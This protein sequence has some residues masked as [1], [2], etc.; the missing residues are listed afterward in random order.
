MISLILAALLLIPIGGAQAYTLPAESVTIA[1]R[2]VDDG[3]RG[4]SGVLVELTPAPESGGRQTAVT[5]TDGAYTVKVPKGWTG[6][7][8]PRQTACAA[9]SPESRSYT[10]VTGDQPSGDYQISYRTVLI[11][12]RVTDSSGKGIPGVT[13]GGLAAFTG[14]TYVTVVTGPDGFYHHRVL[15]GFS[16]PEI[17]PAKPGYVFIPVS[18][19]YSGVTADLA[20]QDYQGSL[21]TP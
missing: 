12:G 5:G 2:V 9:Y 19:S 1:G 7:V 11:A 15:C 14:T 21:R 6:R 13:I 18:R 10:K 20:S 16:H 17:K 8:R 3:F 4:V